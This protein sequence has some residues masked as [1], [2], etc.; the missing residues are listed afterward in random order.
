[1]ISPVWSAWLRAVLLLMGRKMT[2]PSFAFFPQYWLLRTISSFSPTVHDLNLNGPVPVGCLG[3]Y[4]PVG[5]KIP[6]RIS[7]LLAPYF[8]SAVGLAIPRSVSER[9]N[10][11]PKGFASVIVTVYLPLPC[12]SCRG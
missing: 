11:R 1:M 6:F 2:R 10:K 5:V 12:S 8:F 4:V 7:A 3:P 9:P